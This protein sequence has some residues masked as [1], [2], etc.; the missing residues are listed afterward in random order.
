MKK[1]STTTVLGHDIPK[2]RLTALAWLWIAVYLGL[3][4]LLIGSVLDA[5]STVWLGRCAAWWCW[6]F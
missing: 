2:A 6:L 5:L 4:V 1:S 3:P